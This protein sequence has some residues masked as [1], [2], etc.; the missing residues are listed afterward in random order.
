MGEGEGGMASFPV[1]VNINNVPS[2]RQALTQ[3]RGMGWAL[4]RIASWVVSSVRK[5]IRGKERKGKKRKEKVSYLVNKTMG[6]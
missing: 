5:C 2:K 6:R 3:K 1:I 4:F